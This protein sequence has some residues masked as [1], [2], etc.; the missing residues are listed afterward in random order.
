VTSWFW[1]AGIVTLSLLPPLIKARLGG[2]EHAVTVYLALFSVAVGCGSA[3]AA[4]LARGRIVLGITIAGAVV[5]GLAAFD[6][7]LA[8]WGVD[9][10]GGALSPGE[11][12][13]T[14][15]GLRVALDLAGIAIG[16]GLYIVPVFAAVQAWAG[17]NFRART[18]AAVNILNAAFMTG[19]T[20]LVALLQSL[21]VTIAML[22]AA[23]GALTLIVAA[24]IRL[25]LPA[26]IAPQDAR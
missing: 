15:R 21:G 3:L 11:L 10:A 8:V 24:L 26:D 2:D 13:G 16:G 23:V 18:V 14:A 19:A 5:L 12:L 7:G 20:V 22:F 25:T 1:L 6:L 9:A 4:I 17:A